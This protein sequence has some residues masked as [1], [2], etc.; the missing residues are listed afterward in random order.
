MQDFFGLARAPTVGEGKVPLVLHLLRAEPAL[1]QVAR[2][3]PGFW[4]KHYPALRKKH[5]AAT[6]STRGRR[7]RRSVAG[8]D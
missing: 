4:V 7:T 5:A 2:N 1:V 8:D 3:L 6:R